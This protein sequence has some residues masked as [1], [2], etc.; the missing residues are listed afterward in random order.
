MAPSTANAIKSK[1]G[2]LEGEGGMSVMFPIERKTLTSPQPNKLRPAIT[3][4]VTNAAPNEMRTKISPMVVP[5]RSTSASVVWAD[6][7]IRAVV[8][9]GE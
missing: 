3:S 9:S 2:Y 5:L 4:P 7:R 1:I 6:G 8:R